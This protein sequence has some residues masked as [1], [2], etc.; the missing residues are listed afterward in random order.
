VKNTNH[1]V[2]RLA[3]FVALLAIGAV[4]FAGPVM[5]LLTVSKNRAL[6]SHIPLIPFIS[7]YFLV[8]GRKSIFSQVNWDWAKG[9][10]A[11]VAAILVYW[12][13]QPLQEQLTRNDYF[14]VMMSGAFLWVLGSFVSVFGFSCLKM[15]VFPMLFLLFIIPM[16]HLLLDPFVRFLQIGAAEFTHGI[17][18]VMGVSF[19]REGMLFSVPGLTIEVAEECSGI[20]SSI[21]LF[22]TSIVAGKIFLERGWTRLA[23][24]LSIFPITMFKNAV[25]I[26]MLT[27]LGAYVDMRFITGSWLHSSG[28]IPF[29]VVAL[30]FM[31]PVLWGLV[32]WERKRLGSDKGQRSW[33]AGKR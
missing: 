10:P 3:V 6:Y 11:I 13:G 25:R 7:L 29:F 20:R 22:I 32:R 23:L 16:P 5:S 14:S 8:V 1:Q 19:Y 33:E 30:L 26:V 15:A 18:K 12:A 27:L 2:T 4:F 21:A 17:F 24:V 9:L 28:G 31:A